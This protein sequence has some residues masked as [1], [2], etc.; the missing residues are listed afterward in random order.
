MEFKM[1]SL[2]S[3]A[4]PLAVGIFAT[5]NASLA[6][7]AVTSNVVIPLET[8]AYVP[9]ANNGSGEIIDLTGN[10]HAMFVTNTSNSGNVT[11]KYHFNPQGVS[12]VGRTTGAIYN[13][14]GVTQSTTTYDGITGYPFE[15]TYIN[16]YRLIGKGTAANYSVH[17][18]FHITINANGTVT[19]LVDNTNVN[20]K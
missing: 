13:A 12:G 4:F 7:A 9:C 20:C 19:A 14:T 1:K 6:M 8:T 11:L 2:K 17:S 18:T 16:N 15:T 10:L 3:Y 5:F